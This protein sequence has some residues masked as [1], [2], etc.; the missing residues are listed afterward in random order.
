[1]RV[2]RYGVDAD[3]VFTGQGLPPGDQ[4]TDAWLTIKDE[5]AAPLDESG[6]EPPRLQL[7]VTPTPTSSG[8]V[9]EPQDGEGGWVLYFQ[10]SSTETAVNFA[11]EETDTGE[12]RILYWDVRLL[13][14]TGRIYAPYTGKLRML[15]T[16]FAQVET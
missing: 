6:P 11:P 7:Q 9:T 12:P 15:P 13:T 3:W 14:D 2:L 16:V 4:I 10:L 5:W 8:Q 1:M